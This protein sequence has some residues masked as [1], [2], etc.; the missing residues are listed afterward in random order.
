LQ[1]VLASIVSLASIVGPLFFSAVYFAASPVWPGL[2]WLAG[3][4]VYICAIPLILRVRPGQTAAT[5]A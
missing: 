2:I 5:V 4:G 1:G 3:L